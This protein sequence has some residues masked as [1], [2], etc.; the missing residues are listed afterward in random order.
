MTW[1]TVRPARNVRRR[2]TA[3]HSSRVGDRRGSFVLQHVSNRAPDSRFESPLGTSLRLPSARG[4][5]SWK[6][7]CEVGAHRHGNRQGAPLSLTQERA[8]WCSWLREGLARRVS[9]SGECPG[10]TQYQAR[11]QVLAGG[12]G[13]ERHTPHALA[14]P[15]ADHS[16]AS[17]DHGPDWPEEGCRAE[18]GDRRR[19]P[20]VS[21]SAMEDRANRLRRP[22]RW[23]CRRFHFHLDRG[24]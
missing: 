20:D 5:I 2:R 16:P 13:P 15:S 9:P 21:L 19:R 22:P 1:P 4:V 12:T 8:V 24:P 17:Q 3:C 6:V 10:N 7:S 14:P 11:Y 23:P 18:C